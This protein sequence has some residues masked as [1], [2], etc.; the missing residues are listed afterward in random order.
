MLLK[1]CVMVAMAAV[2]TALG[3]GSVRVVAQGPQPNPFGPPDKHFFQL[4][5]GR[6]IGS[7]V[8]LGMD[9]DG[10][11]LWVYQRCGVYRIT[12]DGEPAAA[13]ILQRR[14][15]RR[16]CEGS[17]EDPIMLFDA[18][19]QMVKSF[20]GGMIM[21]PHGMHVD[22]QGYIFVTDGDQAQFD[23]N[24]G[25]QVFKFS[26]DGELLL[27]LGRPGGSDGLSGS[28]FHMPS[29]VITNDAGEIFVGDGH[30]RRGANARIVKFT[31]D[32]EFIKA[33]GRKGAGAGKLSNP[34]D[35]AF[36]S[37]GRLFVADR[38]NDRVVVYDQDGNVL[39]Q[40]W[41][42]FG[43]PAGVFIHKQTDTLYV[44][45]SLS[46]EDPERNPGWTGGKGIYIGSAKTGVVTGYVPDP[47]PEGSQEGT[48]L[49]PTGRI[50]YGA[51]SDK[52]TVNRYV[53]R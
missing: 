13:E 22:P 17:D 25:N 37:Q 51:Q 41:K 6:V 48:A 34:H 11:S 21:H 32:G 50:M 30:G 2:V 5:D 23:T 7:T 12:S 40:S 31:K 8:A 28:D 10:T 15:S 4:P 36:D 26:P 46:G 43:T 24:K 19:G 1:Q 52:A 39:V 14:D 29:S 49:D 45:D 53:R 9:P 27:T 33:W 42:Q 3:T 44:A 38:D 20:G 16:E 47:D 18:T 35:L